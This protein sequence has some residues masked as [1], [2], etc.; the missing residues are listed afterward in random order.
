[1]GNFARSWSWA[2]LVPLLALFMLACGG[3]DG[4]T[5]DAP[6]AAPEVDAAPD[7]TVPDAT[8]DATLPDSGGKALATISPPALDFGLLDCG[9]TAVDKSVTIK[10]DGTAPLSWQLTLA[11]TTIFT[12]TDPASGTLGPGESASINVHAQI[13]ANA[14]A[15]AKSTATLTVTTDDPAH[16]ST[17]VALSAIAAGASF[18]LAPSPAGFGIVAVG[19]TAPVTVT[20]TNSGNKAAAVH[21]A[22]PADPQFTLAWAGSPAD[23]TLPPHT[24]GTVTARYAPTKAESAAATA[25]LVATGVVCGGGS[26]TALSLTGA[27]TSGSFGY[28]PASLDFGDTDCGKTAAPQTVTLTNTGTLAFT[29]TATL[30]RGA[31]SPY[32]LAFTNTTIAPNGGTGTIKVTPKAVP[33]TSSTA[34]NGFGDTITIDVT[35]GIPNEPTHQVALVQAA[36]GAIL[37]FADTTPIAFGDAPLTTAATA[38]FAVRNDGNAPA[39]VT[40]A[41]TGGPVFGVTTGAL[42][43]IAGGTVANDSAT[44]QPTAT[45]V[46]NAQLSVAAAAGDVLC[47]PL[48]SPRAAS[49]RG[50]NG[51]IALGASSVDFGLVDCGGRAG[52]KTVTVRNTGTLAFTWSAALTTGT[53]AALTLTSTTLAPGATGSIVVTPIAIPATSAVTPNLYGDTLTVTT[54]IVGDTPHA[55]PITMTAHGAILST[56]TSD[57]QLGGV[58]ATTSASQGFSVTN[59]GNAPASVTFGTTT[60]AFAVTPAPGTVAA[61]SSLTFTATFRPSAQI[62]YADTAGLTVGAG[63]PLCGALPSPIT[64]GGTGTPPTVSV[65]PTNLDFSLVAC[66]STATPLAVTIQNTGTAAMNYT[67]SLTSGAAFY[68]LGSTFGT[69]AAQDS[70][71]IVVTPVAVPAVSLTT[72]DLYAGQLRITTTSPGDTP[73]TISLH[74][75]AQGARLSWNVASL[76]FG[77]VTVGAT[78]SLPLVLSNGG[79]LAANVT[80]GGFASPPFTVTPS[81]AP[82]AGGGTLGVTA[83][84]APTAAGAT[85]G[86]TITVSTAD[87]LCSALPAAIPITATGVP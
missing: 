40:A 2:R 57:I 32:T 7:T 74:E 80:L 68:G 55:L 87:A 81:P 56:S 65:A 34:T 21:L 84:F 13:D 61:A 79:N 54:D 4:V 83:S 6:D 44:F 28:G 48:P 86:Q 60:A 62:L 64:L 27:G 59:A 31:G 66:G 37:R 53:S 58:V 29:W 26:V 43:A 49:G 5:I 30:G 20:L 25:A 18:Q 14:T 22:T 75:T 1:M 85:S 63:T 76:D 77:N 42:G 11:N 16:F 73:H 10:N 41:M 69:I 82:V 9:G 46:Q 51:A 50:T 19:T 38:P 15:A 12:V 72:A 23:P 24:A 67:A 47:G 52:P 45:G 3:T 8:P 78:S 33:Q 17:A 39:T 36:R 71:D 70:F 35:A